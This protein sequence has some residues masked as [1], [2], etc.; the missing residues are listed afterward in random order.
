MDAIELTPKGVRHYQSGHPWVYKSD[1]KGKLP[2]EAGVVSVR[3]G[4]GRFLAAAIYSPGSQI[5]LRILSRTERTIDKQWFA[6]KIRASIALRNGLAV[7]SDA[8]RLVFGESDGLPAF[9]VDRFADAISFQTLCAGIDRYK[10]ELAGI[11]D[12][13][14]KP[15]AIVERNDV[16][17][18]RLEALPLTARVL[19][20]KC[21]DRVEIREGGVSLYIDPLRG[22]KT[23]AYLDQRDNRMLAGRLAQGKV[24]DCF[25]YEGWFAAHMATNA[26]SVLCIDSSAAA[27]SMVLE[28]ARSNGIE[29]KIKTC[30]ANGFDFLKE[31]DSR[32]THYDMINLDPPPFVKSARDRESGYRGYKEINLRAMKM[33]KPEGM[34]ITSSCSHHFSD[35]EFDTMIADAASD[36]R[37]TAQILYRTGAAPD[38]PVLAGFPESHYLKCRFVKITT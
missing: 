29:N 7:D 24:L 14:L 19:K 2:G 18:R 32:G 36:A 6:R 13:E 4:A 16:P 22:Q 17:V 11:L 3:D 30:E 8:V 33:L 12:E 20:G 34:L 25:S 9:I 5:A 35:E 31:Q 26:D 38:H 10:D 37:V 21:P 27:L 15:R 1:L 28:N 23:G